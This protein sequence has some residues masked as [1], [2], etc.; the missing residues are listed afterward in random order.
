[1]NDIAYKR[2]Q[3]SIKNAVELAEKINVHICVENVENKFFLSPLEMK[4]F[5]DEIGSEYVGVYFDVGN[6]N[7][8]C[9]LLEGDAN[10]IEV[11][12]AL[13]EVGYDS[14]LTAEFEPYKYFSETIIYNLS[15]AIDKI[16]GRG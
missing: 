5:V 11:V 14:Y 1:M 4:N 15:L 16:L 12:K 13:K 3:E 7:G 2:S 10:W 9:D 6:I 8:F